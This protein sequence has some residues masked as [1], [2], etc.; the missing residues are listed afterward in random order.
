MRMHA[1]ASAKR[2]RTA[3][4]DTAAS[5]VVCQNELIPLSRESSLNAPAGTRTALCSELG[6]EEVAIRLNEESDARLRR[7]GMLD[8]SLIVPRASPAAENSVTAPVW[9]ISAQEPQ[10]SL[11]RR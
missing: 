7:C 11:L 1:P 6:A 2:S 9:E 5:G 4:A 10:L 3:V 8:G